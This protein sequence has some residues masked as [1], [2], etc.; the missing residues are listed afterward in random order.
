M[1]TCTR[2]HTCSMCTEYPF[3]P[4]TPSCPREHPLGMQ[5]QQLEI[6]PFTSMEHSK[7]A[8][9]L[10]KRDRPV[11]N[12]TKEET[13]TTYMHT[14][15]PNTKSTWLTTFTRLSKVLLYY[16]GWK[17]YICQKES[18]SVHE[19]KGNTPSN[20]FS[21]PLTVYSTLAALQSVWEHTHA[22][23]HTHTTHT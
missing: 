4:L 12:L 16:V 1:C 5:S 10:C 3:L 13:C 23:T 22:H 6:S 18:C 15:Q 2:T 14:N 19:R 9:E 7:Y 8:H 17:T 20:F 11:L 21:F